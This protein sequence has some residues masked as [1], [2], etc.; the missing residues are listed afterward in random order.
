MS[1]SQDL[2]DRRSRLSADQLQ[3]L[4]ERMAGAGGTAGRPA[5]AAASRIPRGT[6]DAA[7][8]TA[9]QR[10]QWFLWR[11]DPANT[12]YHVGGGLGFNGALD[13]QALR[14]AFAQVVGRHDALRTVLRADANE[15]L[16]QH[17]QPAMAST[18]GLPCIDLVAVP[19]AE[20]DAAHQQAVHQVCTAAFDLAQGPL[21]RA[22]LLRLQPQT[23][24][25]LLCLHH[26]ISD[27]W[28]V[29]LFLSE[30]ATAYAAAVRGQ[31]PQWKDPEIR[32]LDFARWQH[33]WQDGAEGQGQLR[34]WREHLGEDHT[35][36]Q[37][38]TDPVRDLSPDGAP[39][40][41]VVDLPEPLIS[42]L[43]EQARQHQA[44]LFMCLATALHALLFRHTGQSRI[45]T[46]LPVAN[47]QRSETAGVVGFLINTVVLQSDVHARMPLRALLQQVQGAALGALA[48]QELPFER[49]VEAL[50]PPRQGGATPLFQVLFNHLRVDPQAQTEWPGLTVDRIDFGERQAPYVL[51]LETVEGADGRV[52][53]RF[54]YASHR[55][56]AATIARLAGHYQA[57]LTAL[58]ET[59]AV[60][61]GDVV[62]L[63]ASETAQL[64]AWARRGTC[65]SEVALHHRFE[66]HAR[67]QP[68]ATA[69]VLGE[70]RLSYGQLNRAANRLAH[71]L[72]RQG[73]GPES[74][75]GLAVQRSFEMVVG[76]LAIL[77]AGAAYV[78][79]DPA[80]PA[81]RLA[82][83]V[84]DSG[85]ALVLTDGDVDV[86]TAVWAGP[87]A[88]G[89][90]PLRPG[91][92]Q[93]VSV[94]DLTLADELDTD[95][96]LPASADQLAYVI[97]TSGSTGRPKGAQLTHRNVVRLL[98]ASA[99]RFD[100][101]P[102]DVWTLF[103]SYAFDF[104][105]W[106]LFGALCWGG[107]VVIV[108]HLVSRSPR[109]FLALLKAQR[110][111]VL[112]Q[113]PSAFKQLMH[114]AVQEGSGVAPEDL[115]L[116]H[117]IFGGEALEP[118]SLQPWVQRFGLARPALI[119]MYGITETTVHVTWRRL[120][121]ADLEDG[122]SPIGQ[123]LPDLGL[124][125]LDSELQ[126]V[127]IGVPGELHVTGAGLARGYLR[128]PALTAAR[129]VADPDDA[130]GGRMYRTGDLARWRADGEIEYL[131]RIDEQ[132]KIRGFR[133]E[134][135]EIEAQLLAQSGVR[136]AAVLVDQAPAGAR[137]V[138]F[139][140]PQSGQA[141]SVDALRHGLAGVLP[142]HMVPAALQVLE[143]LPLNAN[144][145]LD[146]RALP[147]P[148]A[149]V[150]PGG[151][152]PQGPVETALAG[153]WAE[154]LGI[155]PPGLVSREADFFELGGH[156]L[157]V[158]QVQARAEAHLGV[159]L[160]L[161]RFFELRTV[162]AQAT[163][164]AALQPAAAGELDEMDRLMASLEMLES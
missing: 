42:G 5:A 56:E 103:H 111:T 134:L 17:L 122:G 119:N 161:R 28:S 157:A 62:L 95:P 130:G 99:Q 49:V 65:P 38:P 66:A 55:F 110:V 125:I 39:A 91:S 145:K 135:G 138:A 25:L 148:Q 156:S 143:R 70:E 67:H 43:R 82:Y 100:F 113:T 41:L 118:R 124:R 104:S 10:G 57:L 20:R 160:A 6:S 44:T 129:F 11:M 81:D 98:D 9:A 147:M 48:N 101:G 163:A 7:P 141:V 53:A 54:R 97:Y 102:K 35:P 90:L 92:V 50:K 112:N 83:M 8:A 4:R 136:E 144:G 133:I 150:A 52:Q 123:A 15:Q 47:R 51:T 79:L 40:A 27:A 115:A 114:V 59:P 3:R 2:T 126:P 74:R 132:V 131:G 30:L 16:H 18:S 94:R 61:V 151:E 149:G 75:V 96:A 46:G 80:Y 14:S 68:E 137:L 117:V 88:S 72:I 121:A 23:H 22:A 1:S 162:A 87:T 127:P 63:S 146:R 142:E 31:V 69:L 78:P 108:P 140:V 158:V 106:E 37:L 153:I 60:A 12:A 164:L 86:M 109:D 128:R 19:Q 64:D 85:M 33:Q 29:E 26:A 152:P 107:R 34:Y 71:R 93:Q 89:D 105:V 155:V 84:Q 24:H 21:L 154:V 58:V 36:L 73:V 77:K 139:V 32:F 13:V 159:R 116:R 45:R 120:E 76:M